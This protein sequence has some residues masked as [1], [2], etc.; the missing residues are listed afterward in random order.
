MV[1]DSRGP[2][3]ETDTGSMERKAPALKNAGTGFQLAAELSQPENR[4]YHR[5]KAKR[6]PEVTAPVKLSPPPNRVLG[7]RG[8]AGQM[9]S[10]QGHV[11]R[12]SV[13]L[14]LV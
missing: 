13:T 10:G 8:M 5:W 4:S 7:A 14:F 9:L 12:E 2:R 11:H 6:P 1:L 3:K